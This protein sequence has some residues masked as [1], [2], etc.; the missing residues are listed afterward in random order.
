MKYGRGL[1]IARQVIVV[2]LA[3]A[4]MCTLSSCGTKR[5]SASQHSSM[6]VQK[7]ISNGEMVTLKV[8]PNPPVARHEVDI[9]VI[10]RNAS[11]QKIKPNSVW[12]VQSM[13][14][15]SMP[16]MKSNLNSSYSDVFKGN[17][18]FVMGGRWNLSVYFS[19]KS[20]QGHANFQ[21]NVKS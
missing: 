19:N 1:P 10:V 14:G 16:L 11:S 18:L 8:S 7:V 21:L 15:M 2:S 3:L 12:V 4:V 9:E 17:I 13:P 6:T 5:V 20:K